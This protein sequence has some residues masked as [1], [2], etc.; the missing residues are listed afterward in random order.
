M[1]GCWSSIAARTRPA[2]SCRRF[3]RRCATPSRPGSPSFLAHALSGDRRQ[4]LAALTPEIDAL[5]T[6]PDVFPRLLAQ[7]F[8]L[9]GMPERAMHWL[10][11]AVD[12][13]FI[14]H[15][16]L[17]RHDPALASLRSDPRFVQLMEIV[18]GRWE[19]FDA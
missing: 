1:C 18:R 4:A 13:G 2:R 11:I 17:A 7:G 10:E 3:L 16:F 9:A 12:R 14:T 5:T 19:R 8:A 6:A 15:P